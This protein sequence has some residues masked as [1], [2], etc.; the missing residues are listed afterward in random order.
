MS[1][2]RC[3]LPSGMFST[4]PM[5]PTAL[6]LALRAPSAWSSPV[7]AAA[8]P[9]SP[10]MS[11]MPPAGLIEMPPVSKTTPLPTKA[12]GASFALP[13]FQRMIAS[14]GGRAE[15]C[16]TPSSARMPSFFICASPSTSTSTPTLFSAFARSA[17][18]IGPSTF[19]G[20]LT[21]SRASSTPSATALCFAQAAL[22][23]AGLS[24]AIRMSAGAL[25]LGESL[26]VRTIRVEGIG[27]QLHAEREIRRRRLAGIAVVGSLEDHRR[28]GRPA[29]RAHRRAA[30][31]QPV[32]LDQFARPAGADQQQPVEIGAARRAIRSSVERGLPLNSAVAAAWRTSFSTPSALAPL[33]RA[34]SSP[35]RSTTVPASLRP[36]LAKEILAKSVMGLRHLSLEGLGNC[37]SGPRARTKR[38]PDND[39]PPRLASSCAPPR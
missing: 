17:N 27:A 11:S 14:R 35:T 25:R 12:T 30:E 39:S 18:S 4:M 19:A 32:R 34:R 38:R 26:A 21:R 24:T 10:F 15:P 5:T 20:S 28:S 8:P 23:T 16:A 36:A 2:G 13:P 33:P 22:A 37:G 9:M 1:P 31:A 29:E 6:T 7:T 3:A